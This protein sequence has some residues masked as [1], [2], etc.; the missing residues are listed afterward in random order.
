MHYLREASFNVVSLREIATYIRHNRPFPPRAVVLTFDDGFKN[1][2]DVAYPVLK[3]IGFQA[4]VFLVPGYCGRNNRWNG[5]PD[6]IPALD[7][8]DWSEIREMASAGIDF[9]AHT[10]S[11]KNLTE[12]PLEAATREIAG[13]KSMIQ[14]HL[15]RDV[16]F[17]SYPYGEQTEDI[18]RAVKDHF[19]GACSTELAF[20]TSQSD[21]YALPRIDMYY[22]SNNNYF[23]WLETD[24]ISQYIRY[25]NTLRSV[26]TWLQKRSGPRHDRKNS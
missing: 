3:E 26:R 7:L 13:S 1:M 15:E 12:L 10:M 2:Y 11:H 8:L 16:L 6:G 24:F 9:G 21:I 22:F 14:R 5:Q 23:K 17:F 20:V 25:R 4:T 19:R 18:T